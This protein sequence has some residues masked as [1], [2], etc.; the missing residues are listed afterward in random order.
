MQRRPPVVPRHGLSRAECERRRTLGAVVVQAGTRV[1][2]E[3][4]DLPRPRAR[5]RSEDRQVSPQDPVLE[6][7][8]RLGCGEE[9]HMS[10]PPG[11]SI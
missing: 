4:H 8:R 9:T 2:V 11:I 10:T 5:L 3:V 7:R 1:A 6:N